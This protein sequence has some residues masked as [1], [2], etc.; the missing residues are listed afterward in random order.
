MW[1]CDVT[2]DMGLYS[3]SDVYSMLQ[4]SFTHVTMAIYGDVNFPE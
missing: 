1:F 3:V 4:Y 2:D